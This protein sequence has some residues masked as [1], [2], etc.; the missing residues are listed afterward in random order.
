MNKVKKHKRLLYVPGMF[1]L[2]VI[3]FVFLFYANE[4]FEQFS[5]NYLSFNFPPKDYF[6]YYPEGNYK[7]GYSY[8]ELIVP[9]NFTEETENYYFKLIKDLQAKNIDKSGIKFQLNENNVYADFIKLA[10]LMEQTDHPRYGLDLEDNNFYVI[11]D[12][13]ESQDNIFICGTTYIENESKNSIKPISD[14][15]FF[16][17]S[18]PNYAYIII[19][20]YLTLVVISFFRP[21]IFIPIPFKTK[22]NF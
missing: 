14:L 15:K 8:L 16:L 10:D 2:L 18:L 13:V 17:K 19:I 6:K 5:E 11:N 3:P 7:I 12:M 4:R 1:S 9:S 20:G 22:H 21:K